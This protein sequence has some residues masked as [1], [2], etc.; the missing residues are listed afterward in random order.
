MCA[1]IMNPCSPIDL[2]WPAV[3]VKLHSVELLSL[4]LEASQVDPTHT[5]MKLTLAWQRFLEPKDLKS[6]ECHFTAN[7]PRSPLLILSHRILP[8][9]CNWNNYQSGNAWI[10]NWYSI[11]WEVYTRPLVT[12]VNKHSKT[13]H[14]TFIQ[15]MIKLQSL[16]QNELSMTIQ[17]VSRSNIAPEFSCWRKLYSH[18]TPLSLV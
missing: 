8:L 12:W 13:S 14:A 1:H 2:D 17:L 7:A 4:A 18:Q 10:G 9:Q 16:A 3:R 15:L 11:I 6:E 5:N